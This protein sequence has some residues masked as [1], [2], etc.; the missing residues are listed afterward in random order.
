MVIMHMKYTEIGQIIAFI[1]Y[2]F[3]ISSYIHCSI[4][5]I[6]GDSKTRWLVKACE[7]E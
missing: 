6:S 3:I 2:I 1:T 5:L 7:D 4:S